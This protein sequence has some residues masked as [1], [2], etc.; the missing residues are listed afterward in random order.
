MP[1]KKHEEQESHSVQ[2]PDVEASTLVL[3]TSLY[4]IT[5]NAARRLAYR[6]PTRCANTAPPAYPPLS[7][8]TDIV[9]V[10]VHSN[11]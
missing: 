8:N 7:P 1:V 5:P 9:T 4:A 10:C 6:L 3:I 2:K 11:L